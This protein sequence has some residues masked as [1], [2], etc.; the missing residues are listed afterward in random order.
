MN[1]P[2]AMTVFGLHLVDFITFVIFLMLSTFVGMYI[3]WRIKGLGDFVLPRWFGKTMMVMHAFGTATHSDQAVAVVSKTYCVGLSGIWYQWWY[4]FPTPFYW[5]VSLVL[6][7]FRALTTSDFFE[8]RFNRSVAVLYALVCVASQSFTMGMMLRS[9]GA[10]VEG[11][12][13]GAISADATIVLMTILFLIYGT[14][15]GLAASIINDFV[16]GIL[17]VVFS[18]M[19]LPFILRAVGGIAGIHE[20]MPDPDKLALFAAGEIGVFYV[21]VLSINALVSIVAVPVSLGASSASRTE[22]DGQIGFTYGNFLKRICTVAWSVTGLAAILYFANR[23]DVK[24]DEVFGA[25]AAEFLPRALPGLLGIFIASLIASM[26]S[27]C[28]AMMVSTSGLFTNNVYKYLVTDKS[29]RHYVWVARAAAT[30]IVAGGLAFAYTLKD[31]QKMLEILV[32]ILPMMGMPFW[33][34]LCWR[35]MNAAGAWAAPL[36]GFAA[37]GM[38]LSPWFIHWVAG[39]PWAESLRLTILKGDRLEIYLPWQVLFYL[40]TGFSA[41]I[42]VSLLTSPTAEEKLE[43]IYALIRTPAKPGEKIP[44]PCTLPEDAVVPP[45]R[46]LFPGTGLEILVPSARTVVGVLVCLALV[47]LLVGYVAVFIAG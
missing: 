26:M 47:L 44:A 12:T 45:K 20:Q 5:I 13:V 16:H 31:V 29:E 37:F 36:V 15:G 6:R 41:G 1:I 34:G 28:S 24:P 25:V 43:R 14:S 7:R 2:W 35:R 42:I 10:V 19:L 17:T 18:F 22:I 9:A 39:L 3:V 8:H 33:L 46:L 21:V 32:Q 38:S 40:T 23:P 27:A 30:I 11:S 4:I